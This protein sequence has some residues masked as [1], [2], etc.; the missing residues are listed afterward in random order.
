MSNLE[1]TNGHLDEQLAAIYALNENIE[2]T[3]AVRYTRLGDVTTRS[4]GAEFEDNDALTAG[5]RVGFRF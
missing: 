5:L 2:L 3:G 1:Q 4:I